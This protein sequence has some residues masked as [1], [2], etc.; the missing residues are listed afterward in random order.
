MNCSFCGNEVRR[1]TGYMFV[2]RDGSVLTFCSSKCRKNLLRL[3]RNP[4]KLK[5][6]RAQKKPEEGKAKAG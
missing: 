3:G 1:G 2:R 5:W 4:R 6:A